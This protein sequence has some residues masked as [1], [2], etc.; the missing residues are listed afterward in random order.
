MLSRRSFLAATLGILLQPQSSFA[1]RAP[2][3]KH[4]GPHTLSRQEWPPAIAPDFVSIVDKGY[5]LLSD[6]SG[7]LAIVD[8]KREEGPQVIGELVGIGK[9]IVDL[10]TTQNR[11]YAIVYQETGTESQYYLAVISITPA[12]DPSVLARVPLNYFSEPTCIAANQD[13]VA[14]GGVALGGENQVLVYN[15]SSRRRADEPTTAIATLSFELPITKIDLQER[16]LVVLQPGATT[17]LDLYGMQNV[18]NPEKIGKLRLDGN[19][20]VMSRTKDLVALAGQANDRKM[21]AELI[22]IKPTPH[23]VSKVV[24]PV[25]EILDLSAQRGQLLI[26]ANEI[27]RQAVVPVTY[28]KE[29]KMTVAQPVLLQAGTHGAATKARIVAREKD[30]YVASDWGGV[31]VLNISRNAWQ[32][33][34]SHTIPR[35]PAA[36]VALYGDRAVITGADI[37]V[38]NIAEPHH[39]SLL[40]STELGAVVRSVAT[41]GDRILILTRDTLSLRPLDKPGEVLSVGRV[42]GQALAY[43]DA[44]KRAYVLSAKEKTTTVFPLNVQATLQLQ[45]AVELPGAFQHASAF[46]GRLLLQGLNTLA[47]CDVAAANGISASRTFPN[48][49]IRDIELLGERA[50]ITVVDANSKGFLLVINTLQSDLPTIGSVDLPQDAVALAVAGKTAVVVGRGNA[51]KDVATVIDLSSSASPKALASFNVLEAAAAVAIKG[52]LAVVAGRG[53]EIFSLT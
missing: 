40:S 8:F 25:T 14:V 21:V 4:L 16:Q 20:N 24:V 7:R 6:Q 37:K 41:A 18:R 10:V 17:V 39:P 13:A 49:A 50:I 29:F 53:L 48:F 5:A 27:N 1:K 43:D 19:F 38:Y 35:L 9:R 44:E 47:L 46:Q 32:Y 22:A 36:G 12:H 45:P 51:G 31:Q 2:E 42:T 52:E 30:A 28:D 26:L 23:V 15:L 11:A 3:V 33:L 34:Y